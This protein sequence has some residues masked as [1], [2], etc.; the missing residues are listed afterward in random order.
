MRPFLAALRPLQWSKN[1]LVFAGILF[2]AEYDEPQK[3]GAAAAAFVAYCAG[4][5]AA[6]LFN[7]VLDAEQD[8]AHPLKR[9]RPVASGA[10]T[11]RPALD[12]KSV[13]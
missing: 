6:Y 11:P 9:D 8:R 10:L 12:R 7:D 3:W 5:S 13:V 2:A 1:L 4:S